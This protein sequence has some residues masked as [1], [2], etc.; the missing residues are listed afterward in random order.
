MG[1][2]RSREEVTCPRSL[3]AEAGLPQ[4]QP[5]CSRPSPGRHLTGPPP[6]P[7]PPGLGGRQTLRGPA[8]SSTRIKVW[9]LRSGVALGSRSLLLGLLGS[10]A[11]SL[12]TSLPEGAAQK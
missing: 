3:E 5:F 10:Q 9:Q 8:E 1:K 12:K 11:A 7:P 4:G 6:P 2:L